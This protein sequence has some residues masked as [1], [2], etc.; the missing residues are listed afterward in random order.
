M[1]PHQVLTSRWDRRQ[2][3]LSLTC[4]LVI[5]F[6][7]T[8]AIV[9]NFLHPLGDVRDAALLLAGESL[10]FA[11]WGYFLLLVHVDHVDLQAGSLLTLNTLLRRTAAIPLNSLLE[12]R[13][14]GGKK[15]LLWSR[16]GTIEFHFL[17]SRGFSARAAV[18][19]V[20]GK[21]P[22]LVALIRSVKALRPGLDTTTFQLWA[23]AEESTPTG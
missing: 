4:I 5:W 18:T 8:L 9:L 19:P 3:T 13:V 2:E 1:E 20:R 10:Q 17:D 11:V 15:G 14:E 6:V 12:V 16:P 21:D 23:K 7:A 22:G